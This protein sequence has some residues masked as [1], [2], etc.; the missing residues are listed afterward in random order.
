MVLWDLKANQL[1]KDVI[2]SAPHSR[3]GL[4]WVRRG[5]TEWYLSTALQ[6]PGHVSIL[7]SYVLCIDIPLFHWL[8]FGI[9]CNWCYSNL[10]CSFIRQKC[11]RHAIG[12]NREMYFARA[13][14]HPTSP[15][16]H[17]SLWCHLSF[18]LYITLNTYFFSEISMCTSCSANNRI[19]FEILIASWCTLGWYQHH[20]ASV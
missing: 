16:G 7:N 17:H 9:N 11:F 12:H 18:W 6:Y 1:H 15:W 8:T 3:A 19:F 2:H 5:A 14:L 10:S 13:M 4:P 20:L